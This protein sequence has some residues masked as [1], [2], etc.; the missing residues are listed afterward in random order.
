VNWL[1]R[2]LV[3]VANRYWRYRD[4]AENEIREA[5]IDV[6]ARLPVYCT[7]V[8]AH[9]GRVPDAD[10]ELIASTIAWAR[11]RRKEL[12]PE[13]FDLLENLLLLRVEGEQEHDF[14]MRFQQLTG[15]AM[16][17]GAEDTACYCFNRL[18]ALNMVGGDP[19]IFG[20]SPA[21]FHARCQRAQIRWPNSMLTTST[22]DT[23]RSED[24][25]MRL[26]LLSEM[27]EEWGQ[28]VARWSKLTQ[29]HRTGEWPDRN[30]EYFFYQTLVGAWPLPLE[31]AW[32]AMQKAVREAK[33]HTSW[34]RNNL[35]YEQAVQ[36]FV[37]GALSDKNFLAEVE[38]LV[39]KLQ[40]PGRINSL[41]VNLL[42]LTTPGI[43]DIYQGTELWDLS[44]MDP[45]NRRPVDFDLRQKL[46]AQMESVLAEEAWRRQDE[47]VAKLFMLQRTLRVRQEYPEWFGAGSTYEP[48]AIEGPKAEHAL[49]FV[50][51]GR[52]VTLVPRLVLGL[53]D[54]WGATA[55][56]LPAG[57]WRNVFTGEEFE[58]KEAKNEAAKTLGAGPPAA[59][60][61]GTQPIAELLKV[62]P[63][64]L[65]VG[66]EES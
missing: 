53:K 19:G 64:A 36:K 11:Q 45:D 35:D 37:T 43:P 63:V 12:P 31:R 50:R 17:K 25:Q 42:K 34:S 51:S 23:K 66:K 60:S 40:T 28:V 62:F 13:A 22:H 10:A 24:V 3:R 65:L 44:L 27:P 58:A 18:I 48:L 61:Y 2:M 30:F 55:V 47:G 6:T 15:P 20:M 9:L 46:L 32:P 26:C 52:C 38:N 49:A 1:T 59:A 7:Y 41:A 16:A 39:A 57:S 56:R 4:L 54:G 29:P 8:Q 21:T 33:Q 5:L 14:V